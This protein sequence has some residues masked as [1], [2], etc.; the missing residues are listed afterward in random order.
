MALASKTEVEAALAG[1]SQAVAGDSDAPDLNG[2]MSRVEIIARA[3]Q[4]IRSVVSAEMNPNYHGL[5][6]SYVRPF[7]ENDTSD[8]LCPPLFEPQHRGNH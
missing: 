7:I 1:I 4:L 8:R 3:K 2:H 5:N 6:V